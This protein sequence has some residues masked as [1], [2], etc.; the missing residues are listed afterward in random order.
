MFANKVGARN[1]GFKADGSRYCKFLTL[2][3][4]HINTFCMPANIG[5]TA[6]TNLLA[7]PIFTLNNETGSVGA[8]EFPALI[9]LAS[10]TICK[11]RADV[12][13]LTSTCL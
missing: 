6:V 3:I 2:K 5:A 11:N 4:G 8:A 10:N 12:N 9:F 1:F 13:M 7:P